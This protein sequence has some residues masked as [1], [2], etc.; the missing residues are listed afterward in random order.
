M[1]NGILVVGSTN[2]DFLIKGDKLPMLGETVTDG[3][4]MQNFGGK[5][6]NQAVGAARAGGKVTF[7]TCLG[8][9]HY[10]DQLI[11]NF[12]SDGIDTGFVFREEGIA[13]GS[14]LIMLDDQGNNYL[15]VAPGSNYRM[16]TLHINKAMDALKATDMIILQMEIPLETNAYIFQLAA[17]Y[18][19]KILF[20]LAP[21]RP[22]DFSLLKYV[23]AFVVNEVEASMVTGQK[24]ETDQEVIE[25]AED[26]KRRGPQIVIITLGSR[27]A[28]VVSGE[29]KEFIPA[30]KV[31]A[32]DTTAAGD[33]YC[34][35]LA[36]ALVEGKP[37]REAIRFAAA[38]SAISVTRLGAQP[39]APVRAEIDAM[40]S[41]V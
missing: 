19:K 20:N 21:A 18:K 15:S 9:D 41:S 1:N 30:F 4:F 12:R 34:G 24:V 36:V 40:L 10:A 28:Y 17:Q 27:G 13:T 33:V 32:V 39:S 35:S 3:I 2:V 22:F 16:S 26:L 38:A 7:V 37:V 29:T 5:G 8:E 31:K 23:Y 14:A 6:A 11:E 25:A